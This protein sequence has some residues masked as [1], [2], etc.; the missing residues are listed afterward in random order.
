MATEWLSREQIDSVLSELSADDLIE[1][2]DAGAGKGARIAGL[3]FNSAAQ[4]VLGASDQSYTS[5]VRAAD[6]RYLAD[7]LSEAV[8]IDSPLSAES[9]ALLASQEPGE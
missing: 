5:R 9:S 4:R 8:N 6:F 1:A 2:T 7:S 3:A